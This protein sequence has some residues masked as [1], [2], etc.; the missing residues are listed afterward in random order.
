MLRAVFVFALAAA[1]AAQTVHLPPVATTVNVQGQPLT[2]PVEATVSQG[3]ASLLVA[4]QAGL[5]DLQRNL[6][7]ILA[8]QLNRSDRCG[9]RIQ[10]HTAGLRPAP[11]SAILDA[12]M[13]VEKWACAKAFG[14]E[15]V[16]RLVGG[17]GAVRVRITPRV[18]NGSA[19]VLDAEVVSVDADGSL[20]EILRSPQFGDELREKIRTSI[21]S[22]VE[23]SANLHAVL[24]PAVKDIVTVRSAAFADGG[25]ESLMMRVAGEVRIPPEQAAALLEK[26]KTTAMK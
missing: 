26:L 11:P 6:L 19:I 3:P 10:L 17:E 7:P 15:I 9:E 21:A 5:G 20:G 4:A 1:A 16:K 23:K 25:R 13:H 12:T 14:K 18:D 2:I 24:P 8:A 22:A